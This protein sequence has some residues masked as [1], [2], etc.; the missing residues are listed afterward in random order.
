MAFGVLLRLESLLAAVNASIISFEG[1]TITISKS[2][3][4][5]DTFEDVPVELVLH[6]LA[7]L[8]R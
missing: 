3:L 4:N 7:F 1:I 6:A 8:P 2:V 5:A